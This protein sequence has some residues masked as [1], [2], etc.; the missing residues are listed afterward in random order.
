M[1]IKTIPLSRLEASLQQ[2]LNECVDSGNP[3][4]VE[5]PNHRLLAIHPLDGDEDD[6]LIDNLLA[7]NAEFQA[8]VTE[9]KNSPR[10]PF[11]PSAIPT[12]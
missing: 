4:I 8:L 6:D 7:S 12:N 5:L 9:S 11:V 1:S 2:T 10:K 3:I